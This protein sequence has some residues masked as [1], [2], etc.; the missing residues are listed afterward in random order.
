MFVN[1][2]VGC[3]LDATSTVNTALLAQAGQKPQTRN[4]MEMSC[5]TREARVR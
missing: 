1:E 5:R 4:K 3:V 2:L